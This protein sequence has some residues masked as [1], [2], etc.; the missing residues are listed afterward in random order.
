MEYTTFKVVLLLLLSSCD[1]FAPTSAHPYLFFTKW[2]IQTC[3]NVNSLE[4]HYEWTSPFFTIQLHQHSWRRF[5]RHK[6]DIDIT[7]LIILKKQKMSRVL[8]SLEWP[9]CIM[10]SNPSIRHASRLHVMEVHLPLHYQLHK[11]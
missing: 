2:F 8:F 9:T 5:I 1:V 11:Q 4:L 10:M 7:N 6:H 3:S